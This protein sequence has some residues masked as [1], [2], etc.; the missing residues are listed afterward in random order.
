MYQSFFKL[1]KN[2]HEGKDFRVLVVERDS[3]IVIVAPHGGKIEPGTSEI[4]KALAGQDFSF[5]AFEGLKP[6]NNY[7]ALHITSRLF[8]EPRCV[9]MVGQSMIVMT[10][11]GCKGDEPVVRVGGREEKLK[12]Q[13]IEALR[14]AGLHAQ[15]GPA[16]QTGA[17]MNNICNRGLTGKGIQVEISAGLRHKL[18]EGSRED[19]EERERLF[20]MFIQAIRSVL[21]A[22]ACVPQEPPPP[23]RLYFE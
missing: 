17:H 1:A 14:S 2:E 5:Y 19:K 13:I 23:P 16:D 8:D 21:I 4:A 10:V 20:T 9:R 3:P 7:R 22:G 18:L 6:H 11:H 12:Y 15:G